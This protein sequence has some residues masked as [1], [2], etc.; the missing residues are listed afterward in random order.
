MPDR[1][2]W[3]II[4]LLVCGFS[5]CA[6]LGYYWQSIDGHMQVMAARESIADVIADPNADPVLKAK[7]QRVLEIRDFA[8]REL[9]LPDNLSYRRYADVQRAYVVWNVFAAPE[10][11]IE[12]RQWCFPIAGCVS[13]RGYFSKSAADDFAADLRKDGDDV[14][15]GGVPAYST[16]GWFD[17]P[18]LSTFIRY[19]DYEIARLIFHE[20]AHQTVYV[21]GD[22]EFDESFAVTVESEGLRRW[23]ASRNDPK[24]Q[25]EFDR[26]Q[27]RRAEF[28][29][30]ILKY[31]DELGKLYAL[32]IPHEEMRARK[33]ELFEA[34]AR[35][36]ADLKTSW[37]GYTGYDRYVEHPNNALLASIV[38][39]TGLVPQFERML[40]ENNGDLPAFYARVKALAAL[41]KR[42]REMRL[43]QFAR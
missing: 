37:G 29:G 32:D 25:A 7:L 27:E 28:R 20:L 2:A 6:S 21:P 4:A 18:V 17:D 16:L 14:Y 35:E 13:Y 22:S 11:S 26:A 41:D 42:D 40:A 30:L 3:A 31:Q 38:L 1:R 10:F 12:P 24:L 9:K 19:P 34:L 23:I 5:G 36:Y 15:V 33:S 39:Y 8:S 43:A